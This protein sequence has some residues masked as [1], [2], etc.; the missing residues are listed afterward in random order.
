[1]AITVIVFDFDGTLVQSNTLKYEAFF[2]VFPDDATHRTVVQQV[3]S[4]QHEESRYAI[5]AAIL[6]ALGGENEQLDSTIKMLASRYNE[7]VLAGAKTCQEC[8]GAQDI[9]RTLSQT[10]PLYLSSTTP[11][12]ALRDIVAARGWTGYFREIFGYPRQKLSTLRAI[13][14]REQ[15]QPQEVLVVGDGESDQRAA[16]EA[17]CVFFSVNEHPLFDLPPQLADG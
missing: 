15:V 2:Q 7:I 10:Y 4:E 13:V 8:P 9:L 17:G 6:R 12:E 3:L 16:H 14:E 11:E 1:M 5:L